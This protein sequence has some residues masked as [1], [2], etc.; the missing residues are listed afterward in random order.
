MFKL[1]LSSKESNKEVNKEATSSFERVKEIVE[2]STINKEKAVHSPMF[3][4][5]MKNAGIGEV[6]IDNQ[7]E[8]ENQPSHQV[9]KLALPTG[10]TIK[11]QEQQEK[12][13]NFNLPKKQKKGKTLDIIGYKKVM[14]GD[15]EVV[16]KV[17]RPER[18]YWTKKNPPSGFAPGGSNDGDKAKER[19]IL[20]YAMKRMESAG[21]WEKEEEEGLW[22]EI[23]NKLEEEIEEVETEEV[24]KE[25]RGFKL[26]FE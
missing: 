11:G 20:N 15:Q 13:M 22:E 26:S 16:V 17:L 14:Y 18:E 10:E 4:Q 3:Q 19:R 9:F 21:K 5:L 2:R 24:A 6:V 12:R 7:K 8:G 1:N 23:V 25:A